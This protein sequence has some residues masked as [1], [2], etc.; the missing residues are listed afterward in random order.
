MIPKARRGRASRRGKDEQDLTLKGRAHCAWAGAKTAGTKRP[1]RGAA[2][3]ALQDLNL[4]PTDYESRTV[5]HSARIGFRAKIP[6]SNFNKQL[7]QGPGN[8]RA[9]AL[10]TVRMVRT[11]FN[12]NS[13]T[14]ELQS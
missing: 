5:A 1:R 13:T 12:H 14:I 2:E 3:W 6:N 8:R 4:R 9:F 10:C 7:G 11:P